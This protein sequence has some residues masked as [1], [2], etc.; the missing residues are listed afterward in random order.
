MLILKDKLVFVHVPKTGGSFVRN[1]CNISHLT[2]AT[3]RYLKQTHVPI[4]SEEA[5]EPLRQGI[6][7]S[8]CVVRN[9]LDWY[10]SF[11]KFEL[12]E[13]STRGYALY[14]DHLKDRY[15]EKGAFH[16]WLYEWLEH[17]MHYKERSQDEIWGMM[18]DVNLDLGRYSY[19]HSFL[20]CSKLPKTV[21]EY[22][23]N[24]LINH[25]CRL[26]NLADDLKNLFEEYELEVDWNT[27]I[28]KSSRNERPDKKPLDYLEW[29]TPDL[30]NLVQEKDS[31]LCEKYYPDWPKPIYKSRREWGWK[32]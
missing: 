26:E 25:V 27:I 14:S 16:A 7:P 1:V 17:G 20:T 8:F 11:Y 32:F 13:H 21:E 15:G 19:I 2:S 22:D 18:K 24:F 5:K 9:P 3:R 4:G 28:E 23:K 12:R 29:Y 30:V 10:F 31:I 6:L